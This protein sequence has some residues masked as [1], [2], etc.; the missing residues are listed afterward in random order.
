MS[1]CRTWVE[2]ELIPGHIYPI[3]IAHFMYNGTVVGTG[4]VE[5]KLEYDSFSASYVLNLTI[6]DATTNTYVYNSIMILDGNNVNVA[7]FTYAK[8]YNKGTGLLVVNESIYIPQ[9]TPPINFSVFGLTILNW[10][11]VIGNA[12]IYGGTINLPNTLF[13]IN[14]LGTILDQIPFTPSV[15]ITASAF[16][17]YQTITCNVCSGQVSVFVILAYYNATAKQ[18]MVVGFQTIVGGFSSAN[19]QW[20][21]PFNPNC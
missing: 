4:T 19:V 15:N 7:L 2:E 1:L 13:M 11:E 14:E 16:N 3:A 12:L 8:S 21:I 5:M 10:G 17:E 18:I 20:S 9:L 6:S